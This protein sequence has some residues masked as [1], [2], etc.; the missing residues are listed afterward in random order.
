M[1]RFVI[2][3]QAVI[4]GFSRARWPMTYVGAFP[5]RRENID[6]RLAQLAARRPDGVRLA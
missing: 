5:R 3:A 4:Y 6:R 1:P 2:P